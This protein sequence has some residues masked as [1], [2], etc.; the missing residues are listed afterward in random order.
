MSKQGKAIVCTPYQPLMVGV[1]VRSAVTAF[2]R[3][4]YLKKYKENQD[5]DRYLFKRRSPKNIIQSDGVFYWP[6]WRACAKDLQVNRLLL[7]D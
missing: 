2:K 4:W 7:T 1:K 3:R 6:L 5:L